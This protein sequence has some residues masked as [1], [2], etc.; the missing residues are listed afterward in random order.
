VPILRCGSAT[1]GGAV[2]AGGGG[3]G[4]GGKHHRPTFQSGWTRLAS[5]K[6][7]FPADPGHD[8]SGNLGGFRRIRDTE[9]GL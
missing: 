9:I 1:R 8:V 6:K 5:P 4:V 7:F 3:G 2:G